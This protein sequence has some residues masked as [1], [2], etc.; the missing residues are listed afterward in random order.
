MNAN[1]NPNTNTNNKYARNGKVVIL[2]LSGEIKMSIYNQF[3]LIC[4]KPILLI[5]LPKPR[6]M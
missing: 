2:P 6:N 5:N 4:E 3:K 1:K